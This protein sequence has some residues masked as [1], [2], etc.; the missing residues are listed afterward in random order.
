MELLCIVFRENE[1]IY[2]NIYLWWSA[3]FNISILEGLYKHYYI[4]M[5]LLACEHLCSVYIHVIASFCCN[6]V[7]LS[8]RTTNP[9]L[10][11]VPQFINQ[12]ATVRHLAID[13]V[14]VLIPSSSTLFF[15]FLYFFLSLCLSYGLY[16]Y[17]TGRLIYYRICSSFFELHAH[18]H[19]N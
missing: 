4:S 12:S 2:N 14:V 5:A 16:F 13:V 17:L 8:I 7:D 3:I 6:L 18:T 9:M 11:L 15:T 1:S 19:E 10:F